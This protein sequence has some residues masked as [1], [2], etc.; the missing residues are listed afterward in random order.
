MLAVVGL[1]LALACVAVVLW[2]VPPLLHRAVQRSRVTGA[3]RRGRLVALTF[4]D[5]PGPSLTGRVLEA[6]GGAPA[7]FFVLGSRAGSSPETV[8]RVV[9]AGH[10]VGT[11]SRRHLHAWK[12]WPWA[13]VR[14]LVDDAWA[15]EIV[16]ARPRLVRPPYGK[17]T[18]ATWVATLARGRRI[19]WWTID[20]GDTWPELPDPKAIAR[21]VVERGGG[22]VLLHD[23]DREG[24]ADQAARQEYVLAVTREILAAGKAAGF[25]FC[26]YSDLLSGNA[27]A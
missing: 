1:I 27:K 21:S 22:V 11:H 20:S 6:L 4:D 14:D 17:M 25:R 24:H 12:T 2:F 16:G 18:L 8:R 9:G 23:F 7:T 5:G 13:A 15:A 10:E 26:R 19:A 3:S